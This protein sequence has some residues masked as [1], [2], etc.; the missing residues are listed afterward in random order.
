MERL[1]AAVHH[2]G[3]AGQFGDVDDFQAGLES[4]F[5]SAASR[6]EFH[7]V[8]CKRAREFGESALVGHR[9]KCA[10]YAAQ[11]GH[12]V[13]SGSSGSSPRSRRVP[14]AGWV[15]WLKLQCTRS[16]WRA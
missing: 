3:K 8:T 4:A 10:G 1:H 16:T 9:N 5:A 13:V 7:L 11:I 2:L 6:N 14:V 12:G 15:T